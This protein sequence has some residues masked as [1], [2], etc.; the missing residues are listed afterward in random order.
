MI[1]G[2]TESLVSTL[3][4][5]IASGSIYTA[6]RLYIAENVPTSHRCTISG[7]AEGMGA[8]I[9]TIIMFNVYANFITVR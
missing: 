9:S 7:F 4:T 6:A 2:T 5:E 8:G 1:L 3:L